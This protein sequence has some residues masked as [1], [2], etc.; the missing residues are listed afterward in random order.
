MDNTL[1]PNNE[2]PQENP[3]DFIWTLVTTMLLVLSIMLLVFSLLYIQDLRTLREL[4]GILWN[5]VCGVPSE[6]GI[7]L[8]LMLTLS[9][10]SFLATG[11]VWGYSRWRRH[12]R[13]A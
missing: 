11:A 2:Q 3:E 7:V 5:F 1:N 12:R 10:L 13:A 9:T 8:P 4:P 6:N